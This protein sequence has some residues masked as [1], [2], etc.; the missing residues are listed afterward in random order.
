M[1]FLMRLF[2]S[3]EYTSRTYAEEMVL[4]LAVS[5]RTCATSSKEQTGDMITFTQLEKENLLSESHEGAKSDKKIGDESNNDS[6]IPP[7]LRLY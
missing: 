1:L 5:Y 6:I 2:C 4:L 7:L 3:L